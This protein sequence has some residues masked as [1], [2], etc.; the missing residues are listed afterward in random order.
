MYVSTTPTIKISAGAS[1]SVRALDDI[2]VNTGAERSPLQATWESATPSDSDDAWMRRYGA[3]TPL[4]LKR[5]REWGYVALNVD[6][7]GPRKI[8]AVCGNLGMVSGKARALDVHGAK[9]FLESLVFV[10]SG[11]I[12]AMGMSH[13]GWATIDS[14]RSDITSALGLKPFRAAVAYYPWCD[15]PTQCPC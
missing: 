15:E 2:S 3:G 13:G 9:S 14:V 10:D 5:L 1:S 11:R 4:G 7:F 6:S 8:G 12:T